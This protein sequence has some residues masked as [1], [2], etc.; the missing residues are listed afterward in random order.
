MHDINQLVENYSQYTEPICMALVDYEKAFDSGTT[1]VW[2]ALTKQG[3]RGNVCEDTATH[4]YE[5]STTN[6][7]YIYSLLV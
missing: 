6:I 7:I 5:Q 1:T 2:K 3:R 4:I